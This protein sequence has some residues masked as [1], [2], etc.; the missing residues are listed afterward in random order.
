MEADFSSV[1]VHFNPVASRGIGLTNSG[2][3]LEFR[4]E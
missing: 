1:K 4:A 2:V 3:N